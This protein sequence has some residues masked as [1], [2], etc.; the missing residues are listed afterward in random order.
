MNAVTPPSGAVD[1]RGEWSP[2]L[3]RF[4][5]AVAA[6]DGLF[7]P[8]LA[9]IAQLEVRTRN[10]LYQITLLG[11]GRVMV[12]GGAFFP[13]WSEAHLSGSTMGG[14]FLKMDWIGCGFCMEF[15]H[16]G[17]RIIT[18]SV[19]EIRTAGRPQHLF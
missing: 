17:Q 9:A 2:A 5:T 19:R 4:T 16:Q 14:S 7:L 18:T 12:L 1:T 10:T 6:A 3:D 11:N 13:V 15:L 8:S